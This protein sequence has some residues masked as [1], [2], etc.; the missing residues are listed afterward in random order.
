[1]PP[2]V[3]SGRRVTPG[4]KA[5]FSMYAKKRPRDVMGRIMPLTKRIAKQLAK[6][7]QKLVSQYP[8]LKKYL[9]KTLKS[10]ITNQFYTVPKLTF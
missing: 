2:R 8:S 7:A 1:M 4:Q 5:L 3:P 9:S 10:R 6:E